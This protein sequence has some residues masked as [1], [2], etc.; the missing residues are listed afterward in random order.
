VRLDILYLGHRNVLPLDSYPKKK[1]KKKN[2]NKN[3][4]SEAHEV[5]GSNIV[6]KQR[7]ENTVSAGG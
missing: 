2:K 3:P 4:I 7:G 1:K 5:F 6:K